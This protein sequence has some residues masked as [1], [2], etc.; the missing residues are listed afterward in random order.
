MK[1]KRKLS[2]GDLG[3]LLA[4]TDMTGNTYLKVYEDRTREAVYCGHVM[5]ARRDDLCTEL[6]TFHT[7]T[8][9]ARSNP[10]SDPH[11]PTAKLST[12]IPKS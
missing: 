8:D 7:P 4:G 3:F 9:P 10:K 12:Q 2:S 6:R 5:T 1:D 11:R